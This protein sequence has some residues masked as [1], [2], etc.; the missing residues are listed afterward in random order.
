[1]DKWGNEQA[2]TNKFIDEKETMINEV[3]KSEKNLQKELKK[4]AEEIK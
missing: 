2:K 1:M 4:S 3:R